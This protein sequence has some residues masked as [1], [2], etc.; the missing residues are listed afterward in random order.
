MPS[1]PLTAAKKSPLPAF[2]AY[3]AYICV[4]RPEQT[5]RE[6]DRLLGQFISPQLR[7]QL[8]GLPAKSAHPILSA[9]LKTF[10]Y[11][12][13]KD[14]RTKTGIDPERDLEW[15]IFSGGDRGKGPLPSVFLIPSHNISRTTDFMIN[16]SGAK[17]KYKA[18]VLDRQ[19]TV[20]AKQ[21]RGSTPARDIMFLLPQKNRLL[22]ST[23]RSAL[24]RYLKGRILLPAFRRIKKWR[25]STKESDI[26]VITNNTLL[27]QLPWWNDTQYQTLP[28]NVKNNVRR[29]LKK[30]S[31]AVQEEVTA[32]LREYTGIKSPDTG[33]EVMICLASAFYEEL[34][35]KARRLVFATRAGLAQVKLGE[36]YQRLDFSVVKNPSIMD[37]VRRALPL[38]AISRALTRITGRSPFIS[39]QGKTAQKEIAGF[40]RAVIKNTEKKLKAKKLPRAFL[41]PWKKYTQTLAPVPTLSDVVPWQVRYTHTQRK[42]S[43]PEQDL[44]TFLSRHLHGDNTW[45][46]T[47]TPA[48]SSRRLSA[49]FKQR[50]DRL[51]QNRTALRELNRHYQSANPLI[52]RHHR[53]SRPPLKGHCEKYIEESIYTTRFGWFGYDQHRWVNRS[54][55]YHRRSRGYSFLLR[56]QDDTNWLNQS[57]KPPLV[58]AG[59]ARLSLVSG[60]PKGS[61]ALMLCSPFLN[62]EAR[63]NMAADLERSVYNE[64][65]RY[66]NRLKKTRSH[67][68]TKSIAELRRHQ[69]PVYVDEVYYN[70]SHDKFYCKLVNGRSYPSPPLVPVL[71]NLLSDYLKNRKTFTGNAVYFYDTAE[72]QGMALRWDSWAAAY[73]VRSMSERFFD[74]Y[75]PENGDS[76]KAVRQF[77]R[78]LSPAYPVKSRERL[79]KNPKSLRRLLDNPV[80]GRFSSPLKKK[81]VSRTSRCKQQLRA[82]ERAMSLFRT[83]NKRYPRSIEGIGVLIQRKKLPSSSRRDPWGREWDYE[84]MP[85]GSAKPQQYFLRSLGP[86]GK[87]NTRDDINAARHPW[88]KE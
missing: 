64:L 33:I 80:W 49:Y 15:F 22:V 25:Q 31:P 65:D 52:R 10:G 3:L 17:K 38:K 2:E 68:K 5:A 8:K 30:M 36:N 63:L 86:D 23:T 79:F 1:F 18:K 29:S 7:A 26:T 54:I 77:M 37:T 85:P 42:K 55:Y 72:R 67:S 12:S 34:F 44:K 69:A 83:N 21:S 74:R 13:V 53:F 62:L 32:R 82:I 45:K 6:L 50:I 81:P 48:L 24:E 9:V 61:Y 51:N 76:D 28:E 66:L 84:A 4:R 73:L 88:P 56:G 75:T 19:V 20:L 40:P 47:V 41:A 70:P 27:R 35:K 87:P 58:P 71:I 46:M 16:I 14:M 57:D 11:R 43:R 39:V 59:R 60:A 78:S